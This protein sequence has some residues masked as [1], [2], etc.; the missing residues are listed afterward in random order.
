VDRYD[1]GEFVGLAGLTVFAGI[2][3]LPAALLVGSLLLLVEVNLRSRQRA[4]VRGA[5]PER[6]GK[7]VRAF[8]LAWRD[9]A[10]A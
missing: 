9:D 10:A 5:R 1:A 7:A 2:V 8:R 4:P 6:F 3:W